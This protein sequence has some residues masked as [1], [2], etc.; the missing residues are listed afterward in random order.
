VTTWAELGRSSRRRKSGAAQRQT[1][2]SMRKELGEEISLLL[3][4]INAELDQQLAKIQGACAD[5]KSRNDGRRSG[6]PGL[7]DSARLARPAPMSLGSPRRR[8]RVRL[9]QDARWADPTHREQEAGDAHDGSAE[10][11][12]AVIDASSSEVPCV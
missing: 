8:C 3:I 12:Q 7:R 10:E 4:R 9:R 5:N 1:F 6:L 2:D 11:V